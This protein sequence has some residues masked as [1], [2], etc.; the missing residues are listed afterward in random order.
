MVLYLHTFIST[1]W[2][3]LLCEL[4]TVGIVHCTMSSLYE[5][6]CQK[7][8]EVFGPNATLEFFGKNAI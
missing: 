1:K 4:D 6:Q 5:E 7:L 8:F 3:I 2:A